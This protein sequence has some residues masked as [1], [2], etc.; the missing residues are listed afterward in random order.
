MV[1]SREAQSSLQRGYS[2]RQSKKEAGIGLGICEM[3]RGCAGEIERLGNWCREG[4]IQVYLLAGA[5]LL[6]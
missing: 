6:S 5:P 2:E 1:I 4:C 3:G